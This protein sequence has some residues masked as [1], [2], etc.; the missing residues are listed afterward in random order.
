[1]SYMNICG[2]FFGSCQ[3]RSGFSSYVISHTLLTT[4]VAKAIICSC[5]LLVCV[6]CLHRPPSL[7]RQGEPTPTTG[8]A[9]YSRREG[10]CG[11]GIP[12]DRSGAATAQTPHTHNR[13]HLTPS[14]TGG[15]ARRP[16]PT[17]VPWSRSRSRPRLWRRTRPGCQV[18]L[19]TWGYLFLRCSIILRPPCRQRRM[20]C[21]R[22]VRHTT[23]I[24]VQ[25]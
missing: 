9:W 13:T 12:D 24:S 18:C 15:A 22:C 25:Y 10:R 4:H 8:S 7:P 1:M 14:V 17:D 11:L 19:A 21:H 5:M 2:S 6:P 23:G 20:R 3:H 16:T